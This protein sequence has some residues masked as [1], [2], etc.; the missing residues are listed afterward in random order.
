METWLGI[1]LDVL[2][3]MCVNECEGEFHPPPPSSSLSPPWVV[4]LFSFLHFVMSTDQSTLF[5]E[6]GKYRKLISK[7]SEVQAV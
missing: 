2:T 6:D 4:V 7:V 3:K 5:H 1:G